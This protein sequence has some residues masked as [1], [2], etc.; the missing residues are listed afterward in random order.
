MAERDS[1]GDGLTVKEERKNVGRRATEVP[2]S[3]DTKSEDEREEGE[4]GEEGE[5]GQARRFRVGEL[6]WG[7]V[8]G[9]ASWPGALAARAARAA[10]AQRGAGGAPRRA[11]APAEEQETERAA[12]E[13]DTG[14]DGGAGQ[15]ERGRA[16]ARGRGRARAASRPKAQGGAAQ[17]A[18]TPPTAPGRGWFVFAIELRRPRHHSF[19]FVRISS[20]ISTSFP[21]N[22]I[23]PFRST[24][25]RAAA[26][27]RFRLNVRNESD[28]KK[29]FR[30]FTRW[31]KE[32]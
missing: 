17:L 14:G 15:E 29:V 31:T 24:P 21:K 8:R 26:V 28:L 9:H 12:R 20:Q 19:I 10:G 22:T 18:M 13:R 1:A 2:R 6:V 16:R 4:E 32:N 5:G 7:P 11:L 23:W 30:N 25:R 27:P 3:V